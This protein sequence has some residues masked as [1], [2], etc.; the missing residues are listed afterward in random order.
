MEKLKRRIE[1]F[2][3]DVL[4][5]IASMDKDDLYNFIQKVS[6][7]QLEYRENKYKEQSKYDG[8]CFISAFGD[9][10]TYSNINFSIKKCTWNNEDREYIITDIDIAIQDGLEY[11]SISKR[12]H[13]WS[14]DTL[15][16][17]LSHDFMKCIEIDEQIFDKLYKKYTNNFITLYEI[18]ECIK[19]D[20]KEYINF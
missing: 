5:Q 20:I 13:E 1:S 15:K 3:S 12:G 4:K 19:S 8:K 2:G 16:S 9:F 7:E 14:F 17:Y 10:D 18:K 6:T 11:M